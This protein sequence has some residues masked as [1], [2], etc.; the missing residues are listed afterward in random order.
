M[1][2]LAATC[3]TQFALKAIRSNTVHIWPDSQVV[4]TAR[5][6]NQ[7][8]Y[9]IA[10][11]R[12]SPFYHESTGPLSENPADLLSQVLPWKCCWCPCFCGFKDLHGSLHQ[13]SGNNSSKKLDHHLFWQQLQKHQDFLQLIN[14]HQT[15]VCTGLFLLIDAVVLINCFQSVHLLLIS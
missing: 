8:S 12:Y 6:P 1:A 9:V 3:L 7:C 2:A 4:L 10:L 15:V 11:Q 5:S 13:V 14:H